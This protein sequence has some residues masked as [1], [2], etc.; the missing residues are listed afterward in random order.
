MLNV[1]E[2]APSFTLPGTSGRRIGEYSLSEY[3][4][5]GGV[6]LLFYP[7]DFSPV[8]TEELCNFRDSEWLGFT[9]DLDVF[10]V[11]TDSIFAHREVIRRNDLPFPLSSDHDGAVSEC[12]GVLADEIED[13]ERV[14]DRA[15]FVVDDEQT[16]RYAWRPDE[17]TTDPVIDEGNDA[18]YELDAV[19]VN[20][21][22]DV[23]EVPG[24]G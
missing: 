3:T 6:V 23:T 16:I 13:H 8:C 2:T 1:G 18:V 7:F 19:A 22:E 14:S 12:Y 17:W 15:V 21:G 4:E 11:S 5:T 20:D 10:G 9:D 24:P